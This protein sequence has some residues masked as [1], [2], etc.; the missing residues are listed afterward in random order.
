MRRSTK[1]K[2]QLCRQRLRC[3][4]LRTN[5]IKKIIL[6]AL[7]LLC[8][9][10]EIFLARIVVAESDLSSSPFES[11]QF[12]DSNI[13]KETKS[14]HALPNLAPTV[15]DMPAAESFRETAEALFRNNAKNEHMFPSSAPR[16]SSPRLAS[17]SNKLIYNVLNSLDEDD[18]RTYLDT[19][20]EVSKIIMTHHVIPET[21]A[22]CDFD[23]RSLR[24]E[25][26]DICGGG[27]CRFEY[28]FG[29]FHL[30]RSCWIFR[31]RNNKSV[32]QDKDIIGKENIE[33]DSVEF[34]IQPG[35]DH[36]NVGDGRQRV[37]AAY[38]KAL[39]TVALGAK[40]TMHKVRSMVVVA[41]R[42]A[43]FEKRLHRTRGTICTFLVEK[44]QAEDDIDMSYFHNPFNHEEEN[45]FGNKL[46]RT[47]MQSL[48]QPGFTLRRS[49]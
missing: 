48:L 23:W 22:E 19:F 46:R 2:Q 34:R 35:A 3:Q 49:R 15:S 41:A 32:N 26:H 42:K 30:G 4:G 43:E 37:D 24:C 38:F 29:D 1:L 17:R 21:D 14:K 33:K 16:Q 44:E 12:E 20:G 36:C 6:F 39:K 45:D 31:D 28:E 18:E 47:T 27:G 25:P 40:V 11:N 5:E 7:S 13:T 10:H 8:V 9:N